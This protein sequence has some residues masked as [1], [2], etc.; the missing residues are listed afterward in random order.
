MP[1]KSKIHDESLRYKKKYLGQPVPK[2][3]MENETAMQEI[4]NVYKKN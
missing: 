3:D 4:I 2:K 1:Q